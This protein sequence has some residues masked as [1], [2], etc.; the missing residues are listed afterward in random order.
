MRILADPE[1]RARFA[2][3][4]LDLVGN[5]PAQMHAAMAADIPKWA[6]VIAE[7]GIQTAR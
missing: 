4:G 5:T 1:M 2:A 6:R 7:A 3:L